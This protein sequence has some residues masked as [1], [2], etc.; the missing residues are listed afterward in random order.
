MRVLRQEDSILPS[1]IHPGPI[2]IAAALA[3]GEANHLSG[4]QVISAIVAAYD[5]LGSLAGSGWTWEQCARTPSH[6]YG[7]FGAAAASARLMG[8]D[9]DQTARALAYAGN[10]GA[11]ITH[12]FANHQYGILARNGMTA[13]ELGRARAPY[14]HDALEGEYGFFA[15]QVGGLPSG[16]TALWRGSAVVGRS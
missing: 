9:T 13:A 14:R 10:Y 4:R 11:M 6:V 1:F 15:A 5:V 12:G 8:L 2:V 3:L 7:A 16:S